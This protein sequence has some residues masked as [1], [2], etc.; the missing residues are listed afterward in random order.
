MGPFKGGTLRINGCQGGLNLRK[1][2]KK[3]PNRDNKIF[4]IF[5]L[6][7]TFLREIRKYVYLIKLF[8]QPFFSFCLGQ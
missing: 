7:C 1:Q 4:E 6:D 3:N 2:D 5:S 8:P